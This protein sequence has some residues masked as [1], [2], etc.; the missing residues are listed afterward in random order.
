M[1]KEMSVS[2]IMQLA[3]PSKNVTPTGPP[4]KKLTY[5]LD[6]FSLYSN[7]HKHIDSEALGAEDHHIEGVV[8]IFKYPDFSRATPT[9]QKRGGFTTTFKPRIDP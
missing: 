5:F 4:Q 3:G 9:P 2:A 7:P 8:L 6:I 1:P